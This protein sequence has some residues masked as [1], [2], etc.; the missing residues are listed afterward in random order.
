MGEDIDLKR[1]IIHFRGRQTK[2][3]R[4]RQI[5]FNQLPGLRELLEAQKPEA[6]RP[7][8]S[9]S[10]DPE[11]PWDVFLVARHNSRNLDKLGMP[12][13]SAHTLRHTFASH[14]VMAGVEMW[15]VSKLLGHSSVAVTEKHYAHLA[16]RHAEE[17]LGKL[18]Y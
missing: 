14:L 9:S 7:V 17:A 3:K 5:P 6:G 15:T 1:G 11:K 2:S 12:W 10:T 13:A 18:P 8:F 16:P 4:N